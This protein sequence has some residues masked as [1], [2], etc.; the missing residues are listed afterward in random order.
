MPRYSG[1][2]T[3]TTRQKGNANK[4]RN[5]RGSYSR[6]NKAKRADRYPRYEHPANERDIQEREGRHIGTT[7]GEYK[8]A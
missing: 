6:K 8:A 5:G 7:R 2:S 4:N 1:G 3:S